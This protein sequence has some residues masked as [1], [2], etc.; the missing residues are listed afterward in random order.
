MFLKKKQL[1]GL[2]IHLRRS[3]LNML[4]TLSVIKGEYNEKSINIP[5]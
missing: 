4:I 1:S 2:D 3:I 5:H